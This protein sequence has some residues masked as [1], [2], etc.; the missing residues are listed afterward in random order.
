MGNEIIK[1]TAGII[2]ASVTEHGKK[3][4]FVGHIGGDDFAIVMHPENHKKICESIISSFDKKITEYYDSD[5]IERGYII[6]KSR[7]GQEQKFPL[8]TI[9]IAVVT[10]ENRKDM[11]NVEI[12]EIAAELKDHAKSL[13]GS[14]F[15]TDRR[16]TAHDHHNMANIA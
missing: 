12:G 6:G 9:S 5:D 11:N 15:V 1:E 2:E 16:E 7:Q 4:D 13:Q 3:D 10:N 14:V 8:M